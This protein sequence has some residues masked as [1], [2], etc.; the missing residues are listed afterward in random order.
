M[1]GVKSIL[2]KKLN[3]A[4]PGL[5]DKIKNLDLKNPD[6]ETVREIF[7]VLNKI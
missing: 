1:L 5:A 4:N 2:I 7:E 3:D 6:L